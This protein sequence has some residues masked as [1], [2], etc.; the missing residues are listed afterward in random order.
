MGTRI[1]SVVVVKSDGSVNLE[2]HTTDVHDTNDAYVAVNRKV[3]TGS[4]VVAMIP[5]NHI[6]GATTYNMERKNYRSAWIDPFDTPMGD[7]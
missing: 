1:W 4:T 3:D 6:S 2:Q 5:G 7:F